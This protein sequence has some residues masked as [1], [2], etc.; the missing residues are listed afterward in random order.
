MEQVRIGL[1]GAGLIG[2]VHAAVLAQIREALGQEKI[3]LVAV[4]DVVPEKAR[5]FVEQFRFE[6]AHPDGKSLFDDREV[7]TVFVCTPTSFHA[8]AVFRAAETRRH[9]FCEKPLGMSAAQAWEMARAVEEAGVTGQTGL[10]LRFSPVYHLVRSYAQRTDLGRPLAVVFRDDQCFPVRGLH[11]SGWRKDRSLTAGG[12][13]VEHSVH[14]IDLLVWLFGPMA[15]VRAWKVNHAGHPGIEDHV[16]AEIE[17][18]S[19]LRAQL[20]SL[21]HDM[22]LRHSNRR[23]EVFWEKAF[24]STDSDMLGPVQVQLGDEPETTVEAS[25]V[26]RRFLSALGREA[27]P[28][29]RWLTVPYAL[30]DLSF[31]EA[32]LADRPAEPSLR[33]GARAQSW[34]EL[35]Y[36]SA[37]K[38]REVEVPSDPL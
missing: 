6:R 17:F 31:V 18:R 20:L 15:R 28:L 26:E 9:V 5:A 24:L 7:N 33:E 16:A 2:Q 27:H 34:V 37:E 22:A 13:L 3:R 8:E 4:T 21:W 30:Q 19:G 1:L 11:A 14:D 36:E 25:E 32:L 35:F 38:G 29:A 23:L 12:T 10:V